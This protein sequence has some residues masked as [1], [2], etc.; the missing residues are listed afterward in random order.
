MKLVAINAEKSSRYF[1]VI[2]RCNR[3]IMIKYGILSRPK[4]I[5]RKSMKKVIFILVALIAVVAMAVYYALNKETD[6]VINDKAEF[7]YTTEEI[8]EKSNSM[9]DSLFNA[10]HVGKAVEINGTV[11]AVSIKNESPS[12]TFK[13]DDES[14]M[15]NTG[16]DKSLVDDLKSISINTPLKVTCICNGVSSP[17][18]PDDLLSETVFTFNRCR[19]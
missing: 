5:K 3:Q 6:K 15:I 10:Q 7:I 11:Q 4:L 2:S 18:D 8:I 9:S 13:T 16:F 1:G 14:I 17:D 19:L 12:V